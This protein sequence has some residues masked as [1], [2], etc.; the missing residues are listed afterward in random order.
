MCPQLN[1]HIGANKDVGV[2]QAVLQQVGVMLGAAQQGGGL[3]PV[4]AAAATRIHRLLAAKL[5]DLRGTTGGAP[6]RRQSETSSGAP[7]GLP[8][9]QNPKLQ[10][11]DCTEENFMKT[12]ATY[13]IL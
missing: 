6:G 4:P 12:H 8:A 13:A 7:G 11:D 10:K 3:A 2:A 1:G 5:D 9:Q